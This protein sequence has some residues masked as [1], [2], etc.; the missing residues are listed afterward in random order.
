MKRFTQLFTELD[1]TNRTNEKIAALERYFREADPANAAWALFF[2]TGRRLS[3]VLS[4][5][6]LRHLAAEAADLPLWLVEECYD[7]VG[8]LAETIAL[9]LPPAESKLALPLHELVE[10]RLLPLRQLPE[11]AARELLRQTWRELDRRER[12]VWNKLLTGAFRVGVSQSLVV[13]GLAAFTDLEPAVLAHRLMGQWEPTPDDFRRLIDTTEDVSRETARPYPFY[14]A[15]PLEDEPATLGDVADWQIEWKWDGVR[16]Q[17]IRRNGDVLLWTR[18]DELVTSTFPE[19]AEAGRALPDGTV[20]D[21]E[22]L[23]WRGE[24]PEVF[25]RLQRRLGRKTVTARMRADNP[26]A[27][28]A[29]DLLEWRG[30]DWRQRALHERRAQLETAV[31]ESQRF[32]L[33]HRETVGPGETLELFPALKPAPPPSLRLSEVLI[34]DSWKA[35]E[36]WREQARAREVE[37]LMLK[38]HDAPY[39]VGRQR[40]HWWK[41]KIDPLVIDAVLINAQSGHG[42][43]ASLYTD[44]TFGLWDNGELVPVAKAYS[45]LT[46]DEIREVDAFVRAHTVQRFGPIRAVEP[47]LVFELAFEAV[48][49]SSRHKSGFAVRFPR[50]NRWRRDK[51]PEDADTL[52]NL[53][54]LLRVGK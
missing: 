24:Q 3:R 32:A 12:F 27:F 5:T 29:Y 51:R 10:Q 14:L 40:G 15:S 28:V 33:T 11:H 17:L 35:L 43:R 36:S 34:A 46:D 53:R 38:R 26:V 49:E 22:I 44:Y 30:E 2:L 45:G 39:G 41:W 23:A 8:D 37:G 48:Q 18:G 25:A 13:R 16:A 1:E 19:I 4:S 47:R 6:T 31:V 50:M 42:R 54:A 9:L 21:G 20:L 7:A 52:E